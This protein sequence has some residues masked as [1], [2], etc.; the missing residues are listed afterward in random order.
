MSL[1]PALQPPALIPLVCDIHSVSRA[2]NGDIPENFQ[3]LCVRLRIDKRRRCTPARPFWTPTL[4]L[5]P[6]IVT[7]QPS[8]DRFSSPGGSA[9]FGRFNNYSSFDIQASALAG[10]LAG[11]RHQGSCV[12]YVTVSPL[13]LVQVYQLKLLARASLEPV[14]SHRTPRFHRC[15]G[16]HP[17][18]TSCNAP[19]WHR[20]V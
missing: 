3:R 16:R 12:V 6:V 15:P 4:L 1:A 10:W 19:P 13:I 17:F 9:F 2:G 5:V 8:R 14:N 20:I 18:L 11:I 7:M